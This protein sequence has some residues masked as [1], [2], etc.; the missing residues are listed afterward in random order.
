MRTRW[1]IKLGAFIVPWTSTGIVDR[2]SIGVVE[3]FGV[4]VPNVGE[5][6]LWSLRITGGLAVTRPRTF[7]IAVRAIG[8]PVIR[9]AALIVIRALLNGRTPAIVV[10][11]LTGAIG[12]SFGLSP[13]WLFRVSLGWV[14]LTTSAA[15]WTL[16]G[17]TAG[18]IT[19]VEVVSR[20]FWSEYFREELSPEKPA[21]ILLADRLL[22]RVDESLGW[23]PEIG[24]D[25]FRPR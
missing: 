21:F 24:S 11:C 15:P 8:L 22:T 17:L 18:R 25:S 19:G 2:T 13:R 14:N 16:I 6:F 3:P 23:A 10:L 9:T 5:V 20:M 7:F 1:I 4:L 12:N